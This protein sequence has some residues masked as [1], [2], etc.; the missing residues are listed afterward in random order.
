MR[1]DNLT[2]VDLKTFLLNNEIYI[3]NNEI[4]HEVTIDGDF[5]DFVEIDESEKTE[6]FY[7]KVYDYILPEYKCTQQMVKNM[8]NC[9]LV[10]DGSKYNPVTLMLDSVPYDGDQDYLA[11]LYDI[12]SI[13]I[14][15]ELSRT[16]IKKWLLQCIALSQNTLDN[17]ISADGMLILQSKHGIGKTSLIHKLGINSELCKTYTPIV[18]RG[19][20]AQIYALSAW[21]TELREVEK[22]INSKSAGS[23]K[24]LITTAVDRYRTP[25]RTKAKE[26][27]RKT[28]FV[29]VCNNEKFLTDETDSQRFWVVPLK[30]IDFKR[31]DEFDV[32]SLWKQIEHI[33]L[34]EGKDCFRLT[35]HEQYLLQK[36][37]VKHEVAVSEVEIED[38]LNKAELC[39]SEY[40]MT[41]LTPTTFKSMYSCLDSYDI[42]KIGRVLKKLEV[43]EK[44]TGKGRFYLLPK[45]KKHK[46]NI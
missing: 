15:D 20:A 1:K 40:E 44:R 14:A 12:L 36:R 31:L 10:E 2:I 27:P 37:N 29:G 19:N 38:I 16:L 6:H 30:N 42:R 3:R 5:D 41:W 39:P 21:I 11:E 13:P 18:E 35:Q 45:P 24:K 43:E 23:L 26:Y 32:L 8:F 34:A 25:F 9:L 33:Y 17:P 4:T 22:T 7:L 46:V 28:S